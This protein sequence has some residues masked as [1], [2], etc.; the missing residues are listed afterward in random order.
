MA[1]IRADH[2]GKFPRMGPVMHALAK[3]VDELKKEGIGGGDIAQI[4]VHAHGLAREESTK[5]L[6]PMGVRS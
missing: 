4:A 2:L 6:A 1:V 3:L 5:T